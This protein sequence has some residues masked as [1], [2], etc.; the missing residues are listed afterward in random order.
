MFCDGREHAVEILS[1]RFEAVD[2]C[3]R[4][5]TRSHR[6]CIYLENSITRKSKRTEKE[7]QL[8]NGKM[9]SILRKARL[10]DKEMRILML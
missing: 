1:C 9:L 2:I 10:K 4:K 3:T 6:T 5:G 8:E 7:Q